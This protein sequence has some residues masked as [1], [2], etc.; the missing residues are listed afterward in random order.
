MIIVNRKMF[1]VM[2]QT[3]AAAAT[4]AAQILGLLFEPALA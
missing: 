4:G 3:D 2:T 1:F